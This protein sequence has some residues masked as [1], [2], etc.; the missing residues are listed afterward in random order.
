MTPPKTPDLNIT[1]TPPW[2]QT[3]LAKSV[4]GLVGAGLIAAAGNQAA[5]P[6]PVVAPLPPVQPPA[7]LEER[8]AVQAATAI[9]IETKVDQVADDVNQIKVSLARM[10]GATVGKALSDSPLVTTVLANTVRATP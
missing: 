10:Q 1:T 5:T 9:R 2:Y 4:L 6:A 3:T 7:V 8:I